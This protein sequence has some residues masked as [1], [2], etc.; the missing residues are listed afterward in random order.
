MQ[1][2]EA[3]SQGAGILSP[4]SFCMLVCVCLCV[5][6]RVRAH[7]CTRACENERW[8]D[9][10]IVVGFVALCLCFIIHRSVCTSK[11]IT[12]FCFD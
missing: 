1:R 2:Q 12:R 11:E 9:E 6:V 7:A 4:P 3:D 10:A 5:C 8:R